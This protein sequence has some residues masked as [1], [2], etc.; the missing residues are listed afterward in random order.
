MLIETIKIG[1]TNLDILWA[2]AVSKHLGLEGDYNSIHPHVR[3]QQDHFI[4]G[5]Y[6]NSEE[7]ISSYAGFR[8][9]PV[10]H[11]GIELGAVTGYPALG[12]V[13]PYARG[14]Y[15]LGNARLFITPSGEVR[16]GETKIGIV[17]GMEL[18]Y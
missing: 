4:S 12:G 9:E 3:F 15:D 8:F 16:G 13:I 5:A 17:I 11:V 10:D 2:I 14:T 18:I 1:V 6:Y 7:R